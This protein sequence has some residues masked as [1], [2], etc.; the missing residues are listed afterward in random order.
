MVTSGR[1]HKQLK[2]ASVEYACNFLT[3]DLEIC[4]ILDIHVIVQHLLEGL[5][6][7]LPLQ[8]AGAPEVSE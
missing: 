6:R 5:N 1:S 7:V 4:E 3:A 2:R 8:K